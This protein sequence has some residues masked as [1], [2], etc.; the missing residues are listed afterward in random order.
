ME[1][2]VGAD[3]S[4]HRVVMPVRLGHYAFAISETMAH[5]MG[6]RAILGEVSDYGAIFAPATL[7]P[8]DL[9]LLLRGE[10]L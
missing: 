5:S 8:G 7:S 3:R 2:H 4:G 6:H 9:A 1:S 10:R